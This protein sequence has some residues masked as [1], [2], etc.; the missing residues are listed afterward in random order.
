M[1]KLLVGA[2]IGAAVLILGTVA[3]VWG[4]AKGV[5]NAADH[6]VSDVNDDLHGGKASPTSVEVGKEFTH[7]DWQ[8]AGGWTVEAGEYGSLELTGD[9]TN[10]GDKDGAAFLTFKFL[11]GNR[12]LATTNCS[13]DELAPGQVAS[14]DCTGLEDYPKAYD[15]IEVTALF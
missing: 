9:V 5:T 6:V 8:V 15:A 13:T 2:V 3:V 10:V 1:N 7:G 11:T 14:L 12:V 4:V